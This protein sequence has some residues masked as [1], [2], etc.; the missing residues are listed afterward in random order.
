MGTGT[1]QASLHLTRKL[2]RGL[3]EEEEACLSRAWADDSFGTSIT[4]A[5][6]SWGAGMAVAGESLSGPLCCC[7]CSRTGLLPWWALALVATEGSLLHKLLWGV[8]RVVLEVCRMP[9][10]QRAN[11]FRPLTEMLEEQCC[12]NHLFGSSWFTNLHAA[13]CT[14]DL[15]RMWML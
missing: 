7:C 1:H 10:C 13:S 14:E 2:L 9:E 8:H 11:R 6:I 5:C 12:K 3:A 15:G 4:D